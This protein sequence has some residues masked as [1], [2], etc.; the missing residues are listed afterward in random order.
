M[1]VINYDYSL[2]NDPKERSSLGFLYWS[3]G[4]D[5]GQTTPTPFSADAKNEW[6]Y[7]STFPLR[8]HS[9]YRGKY[10]FIIKHLIVILIQI[11]KLVWYLVLQ[12]SVE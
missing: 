9:V 1:S 4:Q 3:G 11:Q 12:H 7:N 5:V 10:T 2:R 8:R 6:I